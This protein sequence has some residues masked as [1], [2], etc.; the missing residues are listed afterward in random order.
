MQHNAICQDDSLTD[1]LPGG[2][3]LLHGQYEIEQQLVG[4]GF[5]LTYLAR[6]S[7][8]RRVVIKE[9]YPSALCLRRGREVRPRS[10]SQEAQYESVIRNFIMEARR[11]AR[12]DHPGI[13]RVHQVFEEN[14]TAYMA[15]DLV[16]GLD[17]LTIRQE[18]SPRLTREVLEKALRDTL[19]A[20][21][22]V[23]GFD[24]LH[25]DI[26]PDNLLLG[27]D[28]SLTLIDFGA[29]REGYCQK[30]RALSAVLSVKDGYSPHEFYLKDM[31]QTP[32]S[33]LY[34][35]AATFYHLITGSAPPDSQKRL[36]AMASDCAD[37]YQPLA[38]GPWNLRHNM[39]VTIDRAL[40][41]APQDRIQSVAEW[42]ELLDCEELLP[43]DA[44][45]EETGQVPAERVK[46]LDPAL[47]KAIASLV[48]DTNSH[49]SPGPHD[50]ALR[51]MH[52]RHGPAAP[53]AERQ[54]D[55]TRP[56]Q[57][58]DIFGEPVDDVEAWLKEQDR[59][60]RKGACDGTGQAGA[61]PEGT[62]RSGW[63]K[64]APRQTLA[65]GY[66]ETRPTS[67]LSRLVRALVK[68]RR[69]SGDEEMIRN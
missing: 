3:T 34:S 40:S 37:P 2:V 21:G 49:L 43:V 19:D 64:R 18:D 60:S 46:E 7:L 63:A 10:E 54:D 23:H 50:R 68:G 62:R 22:Y 27:E 5:G 52:V 17:L 45:Q 53:K 11:L 12:L 15:M 51:A 57:L 47:F 56:E 59:L 38:L 13:V 20:L 31:A 39:L 41:V 1:E 25:R 24:M 26:S 16:E 28:D 35:V 65:A 66:D 48:R 55:Q 67:L 6:D 4:G 69:R 29:A 14:N 33:D 58:Y 8:D 30:S 42:V 61:K 36:A 32:S 44:V 9:C